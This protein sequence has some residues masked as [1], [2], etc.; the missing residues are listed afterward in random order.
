[1]FAIATLGGFLPQNKTPGWQ[2]LGRG[3]QELQRMVE[4]YD[5]LSMD[6]LEM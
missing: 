1:M 2:S 5:L 3:F 4:V 6:L